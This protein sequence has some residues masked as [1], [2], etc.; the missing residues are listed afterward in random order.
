[1]AV[2]GHRTLSEAQRY[3]AEADRR[4]M[5]Q[6]GMAKLARLSNRARKF[7]NSGG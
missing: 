3:T 4:R 2:L 5:A 6:S 7:D 1:M